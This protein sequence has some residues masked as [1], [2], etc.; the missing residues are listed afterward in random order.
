VGT[1]DDSQTR[2]WQRHH[3]LMVALLVERKFSRP[4]RDIS[5]DRLAPV[6]EGP[7]QLRICERLIGATCSVMLLFGLVPL[8]AMLLRA[9]R[10]RHSRGLV[11]LV[12]SKSSLVI[13]ALAQKAI[14]LVLP[15]H[16]IL[17]SG[18]F[19]DGVSRGTP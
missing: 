10:V 18:N 13:G 9:E 11:D 3:S 19:V 1:S 5:F 17:D 12:K 7:I 2:H 8:L 15:V 14:D 16:L 6:S 4:R